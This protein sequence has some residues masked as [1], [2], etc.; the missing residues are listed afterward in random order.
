MACVYNF[1][2]ERASVLWNVPP[3]CL[4]H[5]LCDEAADRGVKLSSSAA[6]RR[7]TSS[8]HDDDG[9][10]CGLLVLVGFGKDESSKG[11]LLVALE[12]V[13]SCQQEHSRLKRRHGASCRFSL[14]FLT[15]MVMETFSA[16]VLS[17]L[18]RTAC[19]AH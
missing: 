19:C 4:V 17:P 1:L 5:R 6:E 7:I 15:R 18:D 12:R 13:Y 2:A 11:S 16:I 8:D 10:D 9:D 3:L 14:S